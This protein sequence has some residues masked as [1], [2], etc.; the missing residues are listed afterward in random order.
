MDELYAEF[1]AIRKELEQ[2]QSK[3]QFPDTDALLSHLIAFETMETFFKRIWFSSEKHCFWNYEKNHNEKYFFSIHLLHANVS[4]NRHFRYDVHQYHEHDFFQINYC[5]RGTGEVYVDTNKPS[6]I[7]MLPGTF[8]CLAPDTP[9]YVSVFNDECLILKFYIR[10]STFERTFFMWL[11]ENDVLSEFFRSALRGGKNAYV[12]FRTDGNAQIERLVLELYMELFNRPAYYRSM[13]E[14]K[15][16]E[17][18][19]ILVRH[20]MKTAETWFDQKKQDGTVAR[21]YE[22][23]YSHYRTAT[24]DTASRD[25][26]YSKNYLCRLISKHTEKTFCGLLNEVRIS[27]AKKL[28]IEEKMKI[29]EV[30]SMV[31]Y[32]SNEH[33]HRC[34]KKLVGVSPKEWSEQSNE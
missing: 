22:Y 33:F 18:F 12:N 27:E 3:L 13:S 34:F 29:S 9:H 23:L 21:I 26:G 14:A 5:L 4:V 28:L 8:N 19:C 32:N 25:L 24:L 11:Q 10:K 30:G 15:L 2:R 31:G 17:L 7:Q 6:V 16:T 20:Y 1:G